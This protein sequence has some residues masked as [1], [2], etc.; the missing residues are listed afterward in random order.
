MIKNTTFLLIIAVSFS[1]WPILLNKSANP[2]MALGTI[3]V[4]FMSSITM[5]TYHSIMAYLDPEVTFNMP[6]KYL[7]MALGIGIINGIGMVLYSRFIDTP[8]T[9]LYVSIIAV[10]MPI[11]TM[12][13]GYWIIGSPT[14]TLTK[15]VGVVG[16]VVCIWLITSKNDIIKDLLQKLFN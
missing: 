12:G 7:I 6:T 2:N 1:I 4:M 8:D 5:L 11:G 16:A 13:F 3:V 14:I 9:P 10:L 15:I